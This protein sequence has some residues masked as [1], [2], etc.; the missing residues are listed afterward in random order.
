MN[1]LLTPQAGEGWQAR[2]ELRFESGDARTRLTHRLHRGPLL[3]QRAFYPEGSTCHVYVI[4]PPG[5]VVSGDQLALDVEVGPLAH[6][7]LTTPAAGKFYRR[8]G[9]R[10]AA[11]SQSL[12]VDRGTLEWLPQE[13]IYYPDAR[14][15]LATVVRLRGDARFLGWEIGCFGLPANEQDLA[16]GIIRQGFELWHDEAPMLLEHLTIDRQMLQARWGLA[17][18]AACGTLL[19][20]P[21]GERHLECA[22]SLAMRPPTGDVERLLV[23]T[24]VGKTLCCR[25]YAARADQLKQGFIDLWGALRPELIGRTAIAPRIWNT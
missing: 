14:A 19:A 10:V 3:V 2:L 5:G 25:G 12:R 1:A 15:S 18:R 23:C 24:L 17:G 8:H 13:N 22:R 16:Q 6:A 20:F 4:H 7:L 9:S 11:L 21:A